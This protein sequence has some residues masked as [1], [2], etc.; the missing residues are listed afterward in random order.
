MEESL[1]RGTSNTRG[2]DQRRYGPRKRN[3]QSLLSVPPLVVTSTPMSQSDQCAAT[4]LQL[5]AENHDLQVRFRWT[6]N[7]VA[8][9]DK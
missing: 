5:I 4:V 3:H 6:E 2:L 9:W 7:D 1:R 8:I